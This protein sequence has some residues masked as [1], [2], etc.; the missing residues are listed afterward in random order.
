[1][2][3][4][5]GLL[6][7]GL[8]QQIF[9]HKMSDVPDFPQ[10]VPKSAPEARGIDFCAAQDFYY[11]IRSD[12]G[13]Y[14]R[15][16]NFHEGEDIKIFPLS[17]ACRWGD[18]YMAGG[19]FGNTNYFYIIK[20]NEYRRVT[21]MSLD[22]DAEVHSLHPKCRGGSFY[23]CA[24]GNCEWFYVVYGDRGVYRKVKNMNTD[25]NAV[26]YPIHKE[27]QNS[28]YIWGDAVY[29]VCLKQESKWGVT[30]YRSTD[31]QQNLEPDTFSLHE[32]V[33][34]FV[35]G[36]L[37]Q[38]KGKAFRC[39]ANITSFS[40]NTNVPVDL[41]KTITK[42][43]GLK[44]R[45]L[46]SAIERNWSVE[47][48]DYEEGHLSEAI[49]K[50]QF[51]L[52]SKYGG[53]DEISLEDEKWNEISEESESVNLQIAPHSEISVSQFQRGFGK[54][55]YL[56]FSKLEIFEGSLPPEEPPH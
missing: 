30:Y 46:T 21:D 48:A 1:M 14:M 11:I 29:V 43:V 37:A 22:K 34:N 55:K 52:V 7:L 19:G 31:M 26:E 27:F 38:T 20:G 28:L 5:K 8:Q 9:D 13:V 53:T 3:K 51:Y 12:L 35:P 41:E 56:F 49:S 10:I 4:T 24:Y 15:C 36:G 33:L 50:H 44:R 45:K 32:S 18:H 40:N 2:L 6:Q 39:W 54:E 17:P 16:K 25:Q 42:T 47:L 23:Y